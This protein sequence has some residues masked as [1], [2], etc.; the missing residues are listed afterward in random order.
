[1]FDIIPPE[2]NNVDKVFKMMRSKVNKLQK[3]LT[4]L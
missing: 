1:M 2:A 4:K 3:L